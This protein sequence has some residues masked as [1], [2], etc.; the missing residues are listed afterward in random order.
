[1][2][3][4]LFFWVNQNQQRREKLK[5]AYTAESTISRIESSAEPL[6]CGIK[7]GQ[8]EYIEEGLTISDKQFAALSRL[9]QDED[10]II[11]V[12]EIAKDGIVSQIYPM[13]GNRGCDPGLKYDGKSGRKRRSDVWQETAASIRLPVRLN[14]CRWKRC[15]LLTRYAERMPKAVRIS[16]G[17]FLFLLLWTGELIKKMELDQLEDAGYHYQIWKKGTDDERIVIA[18]CD[19]LQKTDTLE[20]ACVRFR[21]IPGIFEI[22]PENGWVTTTQKLLGTIHFDDDSSHCNDHI[23]A[24]QNETLQRCAS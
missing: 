6:S 22:V 3:I 2:A 13:E 10:D 23:S 21:M 24:I 7:S 15:C 19:N 4:V 11:K 18:Q 12:H 1:M 20:A 5:A 9:M 8:K 17:D 14:W 16:P